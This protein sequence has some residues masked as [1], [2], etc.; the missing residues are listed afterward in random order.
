M[1]YYKEKTYIKQVVRDGIPIC[2]IKLIKDGR[3]FF[4]FLI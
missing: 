3:M 1:Y 2:E 4:F